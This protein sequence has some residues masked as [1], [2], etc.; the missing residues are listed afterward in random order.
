MDS[1]SSLTVNGIV[2]MGERVNIF[3]FK[4][5]VSTEDVA[6]KLS[7][8]GQN[9]CNSNELQKDNTNVHLTQSMDSKHL[10]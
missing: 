8:D 7:G 4:I 5:Q 6:A 9:K 10:L 3:H 2:T 1:Y